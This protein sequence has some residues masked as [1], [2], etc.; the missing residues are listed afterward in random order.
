[1][2][3]TTDVDTLLTIYRCYRSNYVWF[4][5]RNDEGHSVSCGNRRCQ[6]FTFAKGEMKC[7]AE[8]W[9]VKL[10]ECWATLLRDAP[11]VAVCQLGAGSILSV[12][13]AGIK[14]DTSECVCLVCTR[15]GV[16]NDDNTKTLVR[17]QSVPLRANLEQ[18]VQW[19]PK[20][21]A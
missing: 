18:S 5:R 12:D 13:D 4:S 6:T 19:T 7:R 16:T 15:R 11:S 17:V 21:L 1:M 9:F 20:F 14:V 2:T 3:Q 8:E 10:S